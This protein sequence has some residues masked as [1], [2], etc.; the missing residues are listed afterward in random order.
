MKGAQAEMHGRFDGTDFALLM[1]AISPWL[2]GM[3]NHG[4]V[5]PKPEY[6]RMNV[7]GRRFVYELATGT[8]FRA[9]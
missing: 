9:T 8:M 5:A 4:E 6:I 1:R 3:A 2:R 7:G